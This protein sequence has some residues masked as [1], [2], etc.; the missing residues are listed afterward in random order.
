LKTRKSENSRMR[1]RASSDDWLLERLRLLGACIRACELVSLRALVALLFWAAKFLLGNTAGLLKAVISS[2]S[3]KG[4]ACLVRHDRPRPKHIQ[5]RNV[6]LRK[7]VLLDHLF[8]FGT[9]GN[10]LISPSTPECDDTS[11]NVFQEEPQDQVHVE[12]QQVRCLGQKSKPIKTRR[13][14]CLQEAFL[15]RKVDPISPNYVNYLP[16]NVSYELFIWKLPGSVHHHVETESE[17]SGMS[18]RLD[19]LRGEPINEFFEPLSPNENILHE[20]HQPDHVRQP[21]WVNAPS[22]MEN[23][24]GFSK[25]DVAGVFSSLLENLSRGNVT[26][27]QKRCFSD[28]IVC[29]LRVTV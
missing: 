1:V 18:E 17:D 14:S 19:A 8:S 12:I 2:H 16:M 27:R 4:N 10:A 3:A 21:I 29:V 20:Q 25:G 9:V 7:P 23:V 11:F 22:F 6:E 26:I 15:T 5:T 28:I 24:R 13:S